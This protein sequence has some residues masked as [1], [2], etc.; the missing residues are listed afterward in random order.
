MVSNPFLLNKIEHFSKVLP[1]DGFDFIKAQVVNLAVKPSILYVI[2]CQ[3][4]NYP[5]NL[6]SR[7]LM[8]D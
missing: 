4:K 5:L 3:E 6:Y 8:S 7:A 2:H 1:L